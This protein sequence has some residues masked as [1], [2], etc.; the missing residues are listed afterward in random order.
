MYRSDG[1]GYL[2]VKFWKLTLEFNGSISLLKMAYHVVLWSWCH[3]LLHVGNVTLLT[4]T[5]IVF[6]ASVNLGYTGEV[7]WGYGVGLGIGVLIR[8]VWIVG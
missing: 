2:L 5:H 7:E 4:Y 1:I 3:A 8:Y 6:S